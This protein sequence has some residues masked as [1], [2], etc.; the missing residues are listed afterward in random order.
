MGVVLL[1][2]H[3][4]LVPSCSSDE[5]SELFPPS[6]TQNAAA[7]IRPAVQVAL[8][9]TQVA[10]TSLKVAGTPSRPVVTYPDQFELTSAG[11]AS[12]APATMRQAVSVAA[13]A[14]VALSMH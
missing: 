10:V 6:P 5:E 9:C 13:S 4:T 3:E 1:P 8:G 14:T 12:A 11:S 2:S 7:S